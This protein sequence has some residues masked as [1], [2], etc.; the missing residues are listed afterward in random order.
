LSRPQRTNPSTSTALTPHAEPELQDVS[1][2]IRDV[3]EDRGEQE[4]EETPGTASSSR[5]RKRSQREVKDD[6]EDEH[7]PAA[8]RPPRSMSKVAFA[9]AHT[10]WIEKYESGKCSAEVCIEKLK[11]VMS[12]FHPV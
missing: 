6:E 3:G 4:S 5:M 1:P 12:K 8:K 10:T 2:D 9:K 7:Q 11:A